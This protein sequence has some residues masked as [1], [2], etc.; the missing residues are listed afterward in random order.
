MIDGLEP[1]PRAARLQPALAAMFGAAR[2]ELVKAGFELDSLALS[3]PEHRRVQPE[4]PPVLLAWPWLWRLICL[5]WP[6]R[7]PVTVSITLTAVSD[8]PLV[9]ATVA[10]A[11]RP[12]S[13]PSWR[14]T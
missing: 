3:W 13:H 11:G 5:L 14:L 2:T 10:P 12:H 4:P 8:A 9:A 1:G 6:F 7:R